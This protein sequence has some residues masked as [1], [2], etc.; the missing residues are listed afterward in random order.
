M[1]HAAAA[2]DLP[3][4]IL[5]T[6]TIVRA[7]KSPHHVNKAA[8]RVRPAAFRPQAGQSVLSVLRQPM[9]DD[10]C[11]DK[12]VEIC[13]VE[14]VGLAAITAIEIRRPGSL[15]FDYREDFLGH[16]HIDHQLPPVQRDEPPPADVLAEYNKRCKI[17]ADATVFYKDSSPAV[18]GWAGPPLKLPSRPDE[19][20]APLA[21]EAGTVT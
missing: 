10:F 9:G 17:L 8:T 19:R 13:G 1:N 20:P 3:V 2:S 14:Y 6:E 7:V 15:V 5:D 12:G 11:K 4:E 18:P 16:A 21:L